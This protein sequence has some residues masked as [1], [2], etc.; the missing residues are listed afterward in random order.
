VDKPRQTIFHAGF[1]FSVAGQGIINCL[2]Q[3]LFFQY[4]VKRIIDIDEVFVKNKPTIKASYLYLLCCFQYFSMCFVF[5]FMSLNRK[6][7]TENKSY[8][9]YSGFMFAFLISMCTLNVYNNDSIYQRL[10]KLVS[11]SSLNFKI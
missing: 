4:A 11:L 8:M 2:F 7:I 1:I 9:L 3:V 5:N 10:V 6:K